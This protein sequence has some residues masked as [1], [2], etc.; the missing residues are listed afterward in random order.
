MMNAERHAKT[1][2][3][4]ARGSRREG[5]SFCILYSVLC[6]LYSF[7]RRPSLSF[8]FALT[9]T[10]TFLIPRAFAIDKP[11]FGLDASAGGD[12]EFN[13]DTSLRRKPPSDYWGAL[14][15]SVNWWVFNAGLN[16]RYTSDDKFTAQRID[17]LDF[18]PAWG[19]GR[20]YAGDFTTSFSEFTL[21]G[22]PIYGGGIELF[23]GAF[24]FSV[25]GGTTKRACTDSTQWSYKRNIYG[26]RLGAEQFSIMV[27]R[28]WDDTLSNT[29]DSLVPVA[30]QENLVVGLNSNINLPGYLRLE[31]EGAGSA[32]SR[33]LRSAPLTS[34]SI[35]SFAYK[36]Y[37]PRL[38]TTADYAVRG[39]L[40]FAPS[41]VNVGID[42]SQIGPGYTSLGLGGL[43]N[44]YRDI[45]V[46]ANTAKIPKTNVG[47][48]FE[49]G[50]DNLAGDKVA[51][52]FNQEFGGSFSIAP[53]REFS[54]DGSYS[55]TRLTKNA[56]NDSFSVDTRSQCIS[57]GPNINLNTSGVRQTINANLG[58]NSFHNYAPVSQDSPTGS[59]TLAL[60]YS[61]TPRI[62]ITLGTSISQT[63]YMPVSDT[64]QKQGSLQNY[65]LSVSHAFFHE[66]FQNSLSLGYQP[67][68]AGHN[69]PVSGSHSFAVTSR[70][71]I[72]FTWNLTFFTAATGA[73]KSFNAQRLSLTYSRRIL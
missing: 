15:G 69:F 62:P 63:W 58:Y 64:S 19:W 47:V 34:N 22:V 42:V 2:D 52:S 10:S 14:D 65:S 70:D 55:Q 56:P 53:I 20:I 38:S 67:G 71:G 35:P 25:V 4:G 13:S 12:I 7:S 33:D 44:D 30:P 3:R 59:L 26:V 28:A 66:R 45:R 11:T 48:Y 57:G 46:S 32:F 24:R 16:L 43:N 8:V 21:G 72:D 5:C 40:Q 36:F 1:S 68:S 61:I 60:N 49:R 27:V 37:T 51:T 18:T 17:N 73:M 50:N 31:L 9:I 41:Y 39:R 29:H 54:L 23:P 6:I